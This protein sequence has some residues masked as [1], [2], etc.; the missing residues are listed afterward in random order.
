MKLKLVVVDMEM[1]PW[2]KRWGLRLA[3]P[4]VILLGGGVAVGAGSLHTWSDGDKLTASDL[5]DNF[6]SLQNEIAQ[7]QTN[8]M[9]SGNLT[10]GGNVTVTGVTNVGFNV[11][12][13]CTFI[14]NGANISRCTCA[15]NEI[16]I[17]GGGGMNNASVGWVQGSQQAP[18]IPNAWDIRCA[19]ASGTAIQCTGAN[20]LC[21][22]LM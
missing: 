11:S 1:S 16:A 18:G 8:P 4:A 2:M 21:A 10:V 7:L 22:R 13:N 17:S 3:I 9:T 19:N 20:V 15:A 5:N 12:T 6:T 14:A